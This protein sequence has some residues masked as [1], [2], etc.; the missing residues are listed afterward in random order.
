MHT[1]D[2]EVNEVKYMLI[3]SW[4][5]QGMSDE[6]IAAKIKEVESQPTDTTPIHLTPEQHEENNRFVE[7]FAA[8]VRYQQAQRRKDSTPQRESA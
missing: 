1:L 7:E 8:K 2:D 3:N 5:E 6:A 4:K